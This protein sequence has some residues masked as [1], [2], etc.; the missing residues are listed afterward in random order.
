MKIS[1]IYVLPLLAFC[2]MLGSCKK[3]L[4]VEPNMQIIDS[5][6]FNDEAGFKE[7]LNGVY[8]QMGQPASYGRELTFGLTDAIGGIYNATRMPTAYRDAFAGNYQNA[9]ARGLI[10]GVWNSS[11]NIIANLNKLIHEL[12]R[13]DTGMFSGLNYRIMKG[14]ALGLRAMI[15]LDLARLFA[16]SVVAGGLAEP[17][18]P[19]VSVYSTKPSPRLTLQEVLVRVNRDLDSAALLMNQ[20]PIL[21]R[22]ENLAD[23]GFLSIANRKLRLNYYGIKALQARAA[24]WEGNKPKALEAAQA[25]IAV[26]DVNFPWVTNGNIA[27]SEANRD[28]IFSTENIFTLYVTGI[29]NNTVN[30]L[31]TSRFSTYFESTLGNLNTQFENSATDIRRVYLINERISPTAGTIYFYGKLFQLSTMPAAYS[32]RIP[33]IRISE[34]YYIAAE[35]AKDTDPVLAIGYLNKVRQNRGLT[36]LPT[37]LNATAIQDE[38]RKEY[39]KEFPL[40]GQMFYYYKRMGSTV[41]PGSSPANNYPQARYILP[42]PANEIEFGG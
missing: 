7:A 30:L 6:F 10:E 37:T 28:R 2:L 40:E 32:R 27:T 39:W 33:L 26:G 9:G 13:V 17:A 23:N 8:I 24:L 41:V 22:I 12:N 19:Y 25:V 5:R 1:R 21:T 16:K 18:I 4:H 14:E 34:M 38:I 36:N 31:D 11:Y 29:S 20:D 42:L 35:A 15:H 3:F